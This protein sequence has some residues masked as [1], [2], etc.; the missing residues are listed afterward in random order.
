LLRPSN[1]T[2]TVD[3]TSRQH[4]PT[5]P[6]NNTTTNP[7]LELPYLEPLTSYLLTM[8]PTEEKWASIANKYGYG[9]EANKATPLELIEFV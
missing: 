2:I 1:V 3:S 5:A 6:V 8:T 4:Q 7:Y 9:I